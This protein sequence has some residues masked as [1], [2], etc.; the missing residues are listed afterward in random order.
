MPAW[1][2]SS[3]FEFLNSFFTDG[4]LVRRQRLIHVL[5]E[6]LIGE[7]SGGYVYSKTVVSHFE[8]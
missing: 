3:C 1:E 6:V 7:G 2:A 5:K 8:K 4:E